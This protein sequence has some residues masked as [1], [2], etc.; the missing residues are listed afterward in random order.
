MSPRLPP[1]TA[2]ELVAVLKKVG[3]IEHTRDGSHLT[4]KQPDAKRR[5]TVPMHSG[6]LGRGLF[7]K[8]VKQAGLTEA[9]FRD[10]L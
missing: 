5:V 6:D 8:I 7:K 4:L 10:L 2:K 3:F 9:E 1:V